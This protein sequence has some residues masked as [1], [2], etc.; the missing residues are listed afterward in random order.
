[1]YKLFV[2]CPDDEK[3]ILSII[4]AAADAGAG[5]MGNYTHICFYTKGTGNW[6]SEE[7]SNPTIGKVGEF[8]H[9]PEVR[10]EMICPEE[11]ANAVKEAI[12]LIHPYEEPEIDFVKLVDIK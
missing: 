8:S 5:V 10:I 12:K 9:E 4:N 11:K 1:M 7:G 6:L 3:T 2:F